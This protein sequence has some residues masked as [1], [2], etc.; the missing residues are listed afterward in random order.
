MHQYCVP[1]VVCDPKWTPFTHPEG[2]LYFSSERAHG[3]GR[4]LYLTEEH[5]YDKRMVDE[6]ERFIK[7]FERK[8]EPHNKDLSKDVDVFMAFS[9]F[10]DESWFYYC[11]DTARRCL[12]WID[13]VELT[14]MAEK[15]GSVPS[16]AHL[17]M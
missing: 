9:D 13:E 4:R 2:Q 5:L 3:H 6:A 11:V 12:F 15:V 16:K 8:V 14:W 7:E 17:S 10:D 1:S